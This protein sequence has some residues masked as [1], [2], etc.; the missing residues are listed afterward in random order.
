MLLCSSM[1]IEGGFI[2]ITKNN[3]FRVFLI[4]GIFLKGLQRTPATPHACI[5]AL[6]QHFS[7]VKEFVGKYLL[8][9]WGLLFS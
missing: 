4:L 6:S 3:F 2:A 9:L 1:N 7:N 5:L 8:Y